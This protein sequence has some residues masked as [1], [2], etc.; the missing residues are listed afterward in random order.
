[1]NR[2]FS[3]SIY[4]FSGTLEELTWLGDVDCSIAHSCLTYCTSCPI[5]EYECEDYRV[6]ISCS[7]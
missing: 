7:E 3:Y 5:Q 4:L 1:M 6:T 2:I